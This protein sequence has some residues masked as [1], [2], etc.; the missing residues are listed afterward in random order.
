MTEFSKTIGHRKT[1]ILGAL[2]APTVAEKAWVA[3]MAPEQTRVPK[4]IFRYQSV[5][6]AN[7]DWERWQADAIHAGIKL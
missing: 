6:A 2:R 5:E 7:A 1:P 4:G 3:R